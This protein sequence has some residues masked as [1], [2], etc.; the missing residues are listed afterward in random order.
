MRAIANIS[1]RLLQIAAF[2]VLFAASV[3]VAAQRRDLLF[4]IA[5]LLGLTLCVALLERV[6]PYLPE[7][8]RSRGD[9]RTDLHYL[10]A[11]S[12]V[13]P[14]LRAGTFF[15]FAPLCTLVGDGVWPAEWPLV[16]QTVL[17]VGIREFCH[18]WLHRY[19][20]RR[21]GL[22]WRFHAVHHSPSRIYW[23]NASRMHAGNL[24]ADSIAGIGPLIAL[25]AGAD[26]MY[27]TGI[28]IGGMNMFAHANL[29]LRVGPL[30]WIFSLPELHRWHHARDTRVANHNYGDVL[31]LFDVLFGTRL[32]PRERFPDGAA[33]L[34]RPGDVPDGFLAQ[35]A[36][37]LNAVTGS[38]RAAGNPPPAR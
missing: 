15:A 12:L 19:T 10:A 31:I 34:D 28:V 16:L 1:R 30:S 37:P 14:A 33:G 13:H 2:P 25:G 3:T 8:N 21:G 6:I 36:Y 27:L 23:L 4:G 29:D 24:A 20:H 17:A 5:V 9:L 38:G 35:L 7:W 26:V 18:Y 11:N 22:L 32:A